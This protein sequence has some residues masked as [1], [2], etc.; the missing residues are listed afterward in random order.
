MDLRI[1]G[2][3]RSGIAVLGVGRWCHRARRMESIMRQVAHI[4]E[5]REN[6]RLLSANE[7]DDDDHDGISLYP[8]SVL[9]LRS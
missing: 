1:H 6:I 5:V 8:C 3:S 7:S 4:K 9:R 2:R